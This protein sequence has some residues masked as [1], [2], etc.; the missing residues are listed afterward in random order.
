MICSFPSSYIRYDPVYTGWCF[1]SNV[2]VVSQLNF[3]KKLFTISIHLLLSDILKFIMVGA[4]IAQQVGAAPL[5]FTVFPPTQ[6]WHFSFH[7]AHI[8]L[9]TSFWLEYSN[10][11]PL[12]FYKAGSIFGL[13]IMQNN[14]KRVLTQT[15]NCTYV[16]V[17]LTSNI[18]KKIGWQKWH[19]SP[20][21]KQFWAIVALRSAE[22]GF[23]P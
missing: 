12:N 11:S 1:D 19:P 4:L 16:F 8:K 18:Q 5:I 9:T 23:P 13:K 7:I 21:T 15:Q 3:L 10:I 6:K 2:K 17:S 20:S 14:P 22:S